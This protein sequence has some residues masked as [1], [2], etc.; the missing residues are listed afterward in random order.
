MARGPRKSQIEIFKD[1][2]LFT[3]EKISKLEDQLKELK[4]TKKQL[5]KDLKI[6]EMEELS[7]LLEEKNISV[8]EVRKLIEN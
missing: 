4:N 7:N 3:T 6:C 1:Q 5:E 8:E 2:L